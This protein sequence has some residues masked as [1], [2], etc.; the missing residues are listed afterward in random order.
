[1]P[2][3]SGDIHTDV[4]ETTHF[5]Y[6][7]VAAD[8]KVDHVARVF[9]SVANNYDLMNDLMSLGS[10]RLMKRLTVEMSAVRQGQTILD[11]AGGTGDL[12]AHFSPRVGAAGQVILCDIN[13]S[14]LNLGR[15]KLLDKGLAAN[16]SYIQ[17]DAEQL[18]FASDHFDCVT[19]GFGLRN[20]TRK[21]KALASML[22]VLKPG[23]RLLVL[24]FSSPGNQALQ[25]VYDVYSRLW[26]KVGKW[27]T[28]DSES[29]QYLVESIR[30][31]PDQEELKSIMQ[32]AGYSNCSY[33][34]LMGGIAAIHKGFKS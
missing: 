15:D 5:G 29:Y 7:Q 33:H 2:K 20:F 24:E 25:K 1:M 17:A 14:M 9:H 12:A 4:Q 10:H 16:V 28:G 32:D 30:V 3:K 22:R 6:R 18:P 11:L 34:N 27:I 26:P 13:R 19:I 8:E 21:D 23:G 31:H